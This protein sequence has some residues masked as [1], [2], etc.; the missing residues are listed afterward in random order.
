[1][2]ICN[3]WRNRR[4][5]GWLLAAG[6][7]MNGSEIPAA[8]PVLSQDF[9]K[10]AVGKPPEGFLILDGLF[11]VKEEGADR[12]LEL[13]GAPLES[14][15][16]MFGAGNKENWG[17]QAKVF[18]T[19]QGRR[20]P[21]FGVSLN[22][23]AGYRIQVAPAKRAIELLKGDEPRVTAPFVWE[24]GTWTQVRVQVRKVGERA[25][26]VEGKAWKDGTQEPASWMIS[27]DE[28]EAP[29]GGRAAVWGKPFSGLPI[30][31][32]DLKILP[33]EK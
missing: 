33:A 6:I 8:E 24:S 14:Y 9:S 13:P 7:A 25:W 31:F 3:T 28:T 16:V 30:R 11:E 1:M 2:S 27:W 19:G 23:V 32:D 15:G 4:V 5:A 21:V 29:I 10:A 18:G 26:K 17:A 12:W 22:G 20:Y